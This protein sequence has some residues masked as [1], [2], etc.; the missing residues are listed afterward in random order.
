MHVVFTAAMLE[1]D[2][3]TNAF[4]LLR[5]HCKISIIRIG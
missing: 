2:R 4:V 5:E 3:I 1:S